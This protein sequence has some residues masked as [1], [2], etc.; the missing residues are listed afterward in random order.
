MLSL[1]NDL[2]ESVESRHKVVHLFLGHACGVFAADIVHMFDDNGQVEKS[3]DLS[4]LPTR[5]DAEL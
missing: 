3:Q 4:K 5:N 2:N 1:G